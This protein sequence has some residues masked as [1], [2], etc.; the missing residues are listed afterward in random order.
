[1]T[2]ANRYP[3]VSD[4]EWGLLH[5]CYAAPNDWVP[6]LIYADWLEERG[7]RPE[8]V[9]RIRI[10]HELDKIKRCRATWAVHLRQYMYH[11]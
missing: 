6:R 7:F 1:M 11:H 2:H 9:E 10:E 4:I 3:A 8:R 5:S